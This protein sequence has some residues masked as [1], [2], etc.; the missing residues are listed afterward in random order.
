MRTRW[1][2]TKSSFV[3]ATQWQ[4]TNTHQLL[5]LMLLLFS[6]SIQSHVKRYA[7]K[8]TPTNKWIIMISKCENRKLQRRERRWQKKDSMTL[9]HIIKGMPLSF[10]AISLRHSIVFCSVSCRTETDTLSEGG[11]HEYFITFY[12]QSLLVSVQRAGALNSKLTKTWFK[13]FI[14]FYFILFPSR[15]HFKLRILCNI[16]YSISWTRLEPTKFA[17]TLEICIDVV[18][19]V[20]EEEIYKRN[21]ILNYFS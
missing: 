13:S 21:W 3:T 18:V 8:N 14:L 4:Q 16:N 10:D 19:S 9:Q 7:K 20:W 15:L 6:C 17:N 5:L 1:S 12:E 11:L 2:G